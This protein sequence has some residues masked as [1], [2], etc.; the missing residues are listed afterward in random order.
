MYNYCGNLL[1]YL[2]VFKRVI[3]LNMSKY[4]FNDSNYKIVTSVIRNIYKIYQAI[5]YEAVL[6]L[7][8]CKEP[9]DVIKDD[10]LFFYIIADNVEASVIKL[11]RLLSKRKIKYRLA[12]I[13]DFDLITKVFFR[14]YLSK[15]GIDVTAP[16]I[17]IEKFRFDNFLKEDFLGSFDIG[18]LILP[19]L[20]N[21]YSMIVEGA[22]EYEAVKINKNDIVF[23]CGANIGSFTSL[24]LSKGSEVHAFEPIPDTYSL[25]E[26]H[27]RNHYGPRLHLNKLGLSNKKGVIDYYLFGPAS[28]AN[29]YMFQS[30]DRI[31]CNTTTI[32]LY[33]KENAVPRVD[34][35][36][37]DIEGAEK[38]MLLG[39]AETIK[40]FNPKIS[41]C[42]YHFPN[43]AQEI[44][45]IIKSI[46]N[47]YNIIHKWSKCYA[48]V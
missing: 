42:T 37:A 15:K 21:D 35:I 3:L 44:E 8:S 20:Y 16:V 7:V 9:N 28:G 32:D 39:A 47:K 26:Y 33:V 29:G 22:Y 30:N 2:K 12:D 4:K 5:D 38:D 17:E 18:D 23:D 31:K 11:T 36:K 34:F 6:N 46:N 45:M 43:D 27:L 14:N 19:S 40:R 25:L 41:I 1:S 24:A 10:D 48:Y 13:Q